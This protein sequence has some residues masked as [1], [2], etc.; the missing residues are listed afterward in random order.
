M[1]STWFD[2]NGA[3]LVGALFFE[4]ASEALVLPVAALLLVFGMLGSVTAP[5]DRATWV[6]LA[7]VALGGPLALMVVHPPGWTASAAAP[8]YWGGIIWPTLLTCVP[9]AFVWVARRRKNP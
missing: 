6:V 7:G 4:A 2:P 5:R 1:A 9:L 8:G 3:G